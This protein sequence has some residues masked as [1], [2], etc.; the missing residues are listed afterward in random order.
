[1][2]RWRLTCGYALVAGLALSAC[3]GQTESPESDVIAGTYQCNDDK[4]FSFKTARGSEA[5]TLQLGEESYT[6]Q[7]HPGA[8]RFEYGND[9]VT[10]WTESG[11]RFAN[12]EGTPES[13]Q[14]CEAIAWQGDSLG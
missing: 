3:A 11:G 10:F 5:L 2:T 12:L 7:E 8:G 9:D 1:M 13:Y 6:L 14:D 4:T